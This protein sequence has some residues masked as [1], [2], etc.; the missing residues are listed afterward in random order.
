MIPNLTVT[1][2]QLKDWFKLY[3]DSS[4]VTREYARIKLEQHFGTVERAHRVM[5]PC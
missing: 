2:A 4:L 1:G 5:Q 3:N